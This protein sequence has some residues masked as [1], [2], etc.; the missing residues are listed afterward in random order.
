MTENLSAIETPSRWQRCPL[1]EEEWGKLRGCIFYRHGDQECS[2][3]CVECA[4]SVKSLYQISVQFPIPGSDT[5]L[6]ES[7][8]FKQ[9]LRQKGLAIARWNYAVVTYGAMR[10][11]LRSKPMGMTVTTKTE[12]SHYDNVF[13]AWFAIK[14][15]IEKGDFEETSD[16]W[17][18]KARGAERRGTLDVL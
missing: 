16:S 13:Q 7:P 10:F 4:E 2:W 14:A 15:M 6:C 17:Q 3:V 9:V 1:C 11:V 5:M 18:R 12:T 8:F